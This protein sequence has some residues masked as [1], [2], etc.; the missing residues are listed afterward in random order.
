M[1]KQDVDEYVSTEEEYTPPIFSIKVLELISKTI[2]ENF[3]GS[4]ILSILKSEGIEK[5][6]YPKT[7]WRILFDLFSEIQRGVVVSE[8]STAKL[9]IPYN[10]HKTISIIQEFLYPLNHNADE[11]KADKLAKEIE[12]IIKYDKLV[13]IHLKDKYIITDEAGKDVLFDQHSEEQG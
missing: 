5:V 1:V 6:E 2:G 7:K 4:E 8:K 13:M 10:E 9:K 11:E 12:K 3:T